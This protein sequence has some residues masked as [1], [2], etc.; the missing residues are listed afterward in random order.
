MESLHFSGSL[1]WVSMVPAM[2]ITSVRNQTVR[3]MWSREDSWIKQKGAG[4]FLKYRTG[5]Y[6]SVVSYSADAV[7]LCERV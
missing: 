3:A 5:V 2:C 6:F 4:I 7:K 1:I